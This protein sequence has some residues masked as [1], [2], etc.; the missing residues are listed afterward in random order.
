MFYPQPIRHVLNRLELLDCI[1]KSH[2]WNRVTRRNFPN[3]VI[4]K[5]DVRYI[6]YPGGI[7]QKKRAIRRRQY[8]VCMM[9]M[10]SISAFFVI[11]LS[12]LLF[13]LSFY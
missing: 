5:R 9:D 6:R 13:R 10:L 11:F 8:M 4:P 1:Y 3:N 12:L 2:V 7:L